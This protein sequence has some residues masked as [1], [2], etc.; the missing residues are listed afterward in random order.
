MHF[1]ISVCLCMLL[2]QIGCPTAATAQ[3]HF[4]AAD[5]VSATATVKPLYQI[6]DDSYKPRKASVSFLKSTDILNFRSVRAEHVS[7]LSTGTSGGG[8]VKLYSTGTDAL[9]SESAVTVRR[10]NGIA[11]INEE[12]D[13]EDDWDDFGSGNGNGTGLTPGDPGTPAPIG[14]SSILLFFALAYVA[15][16]SIKQTR[17]SKL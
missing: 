3:T 7:L 17:L 2:L 4:Q 14:S 13:G 11:P 16:I 12:S 10:S 9:P 6:S 8:S 1:F 5:Q 15:Y